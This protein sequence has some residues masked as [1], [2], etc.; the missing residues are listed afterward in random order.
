M[1]TSSGSALYGVSEAASGLLGGNRAGVIGDNNTGDGVIGLSA[2]ANGVK[3]VTTANGASG[4]L[5]EDENTAAGGAGV[6]GTSDVGVGVY[7]QSVGPSGLAPQ[8][9][10]AGV[11]GDS[12]GSLGV[13]GLSS[14][15]SGVFG[16]TSATNS[17]GSMGT[18]RPARA[19]IRSACTG[20]RR[21][22]PASSAKASERA[23]CSVLRSQG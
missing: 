19:R 21:T 6:K 7:G 17:Q 23:H 12:N 5:G 22:T 10:I 13:M 18:N 2:G 14:A 16:Q 20:S 1:T 9:P 4:V 8:N 3:G 11:I 15:E